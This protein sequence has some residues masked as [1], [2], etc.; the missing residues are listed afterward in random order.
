MLA[1]VLMVPSRVAAFAIHD[2]RVFI[3]HFCDLTLIV[4]RLGQRAVLALG[5]RRDSSKIR[6][7]EIYKHQSVNSP[8]ANLREEMLPQT[9]S[10]VEAYYVHSCSSPRISKLALG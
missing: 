4:R 1:I 7:L 3:R 5:K 9:S 6:S 10:E 8:S 2:W